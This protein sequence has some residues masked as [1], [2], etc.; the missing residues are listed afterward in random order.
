MQ[1]YP[2]EWERRCYSEL[3]EG[4][5]KMCEN[6]GLLSI[7]YRKRRLV[8]L[9]ALSTVVVLTPSMTSWGSDLTQVLS[10]RPHPLSV[11]LKD[12]GTGW[13]RV[14]VSVHEGGS[15]SLNIGVNVSGSSAGSTSQNNNSL[16]I[17][18]GGQA[19]VTKG[20][21][22][23]V[24]GQAYLVAYH[25]PS[26]AM[27][28]TTLLQAAATKT[29]PELQVLTPESSL[30]LSL[31]NVRDIVSIEDVRVFD[32]KWEIAQSQEAAQKLINL[33]KAASE[34]AKPAKTPQTE[35]PQKPEKK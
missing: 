29:M 22:V 3:K 15:A 34:G 11:K 18:G 21:T 26:T 24:N 10:G 14:R 7:T 5:F 12:L 28:L 23:S 25:L 1:D 13:S 19:Y 27:D 4:A 6:R 32:M 31:L 2:L 16:S 35:N 17:F 8:V 9:L 30:R 20:Q 33:I